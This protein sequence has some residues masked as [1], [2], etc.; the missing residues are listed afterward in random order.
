MKFMTSKYDGYILLVML[1]GA[2]FVVALAI[3]YGAA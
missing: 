3:H 2:V 1:I